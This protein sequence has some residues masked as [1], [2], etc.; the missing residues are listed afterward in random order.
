M[1]A[2]LGNLYYLCLGPLYRRLRAEMKLQ[3]REFEGINRARL[4]EKQLAKTSSEL[5]KLRCHSRE[6]TVEPRV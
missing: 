2:I 3:L 1:N 6:E 5:N 4:L